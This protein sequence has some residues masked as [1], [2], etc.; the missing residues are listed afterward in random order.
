MANH[1][2]AGVIGVGSMGKN[3][4][5]VYAQAL[6]EVKLIGVADLDKEKALSVAQCYECR[7]YQN[8]R[9]LLEEDLDL[10]SIALPT[11]L[12][13]EVARQAIE[14]KLNVLIEKP[15]T[16]NIE[17]ADSLIELARQYNVKVMVGH[18]ERFNPAVDKLK[19][20]IAE[21]MLGEIISL[22]AKRVGPQNTRI[23]DVGIIL[24]LGAHDIDVMCYLYGAQ[25]KSVYAVAGSTFHPREDYAVMT[26][27][28]NNGSSG[29][30]D[31]NW[32]TPYK[33]RKL[34]VVGTK[35]IGEVDYQEA[36][37]KLYDR[38]WIKEAKIVK[39]EPLKRELEHFVNCVRLNKEPLVG[40][41]E[42]KHALEVALAAI[43]SAKQGRVCEIV[44]L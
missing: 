21:G 33:L 24:D 27:R 34:T 15:V 19:K 14:K 26:L 39:E 8:C 11:T 3:H 37:L 23:N 10:V 7:A 12:H 38:E 30:I 36:S 1:I 43:Q 5:R 18:I 6:P 29:V 2:K 44:G 13:Y 4:A 9:E 40:L 16:Q 25:V 32:L 28:F 22:S 20:L 17:E 35:V 41:K 42:G 31:T